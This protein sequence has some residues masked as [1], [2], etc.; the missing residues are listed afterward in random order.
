MI[1]PRREL[2]AENKRNARFSGSDV[3]H[4]VDPTTNYTTIL[5][6]QSP[7]EPIVRK[8]HDH[9]AAIFGK[10]LPYWISSHTNS[11]DK[12]FIPS[13]ITPERVSVEVKSEKDAIKF[14]DWIQM[15]PQPNHITVIASAAITVWDNP[16]FH[17]AQT[18]N[19]MNPN[20]TTQEI[21]PRFKG[22]Y[23][24]LNRA[25]CSDLHVMEFLDDWQTNKGYQNIKLVD[26][27]LQ[28][29]T[30][31]EQARI[32]E[33]F[34]I[35]ELADGKESLAFRYPT[36]ECSQI[37]AFQ[38]EYSHRE[39]IVRESDGVVASIFLN[40]KRFEFVVHDFNQE[41]MRGEMEDVAIEN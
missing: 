4:C 30:A 13:Y 25:K 39:Y 35:E 24:V 3:L 34:E 1:R 16:K 9:V 6:K 12:L 26:I 29:T 33:L 23:L 8:V 10:Q 31:F 19:M 21:L 22:K 15:I 32:R 36:E 7:H 27:F 2:R 5:L 18:L 40:A 37:N 11:Q 28:V 20:F 17:R 41:E 14:D 38:K